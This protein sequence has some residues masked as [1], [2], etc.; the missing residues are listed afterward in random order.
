M[1]S[2]NYNKEFLG[3]LVKEGGISLEMWNEFARNQQNYRKTP[4]TKGINP[5][6]GKEHY[7]H[8]NSYS[9]LEN[10]TE[11]GLLAW[12]ESEC[13]GVAGESKRLEL[14]INKL[15]REFDAVFETLQ[16]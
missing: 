15:S 8:S 16:S 7:Y 11:I 2:I 10:D 9:V 14:E 12:E 13:I 1:K 4:P 6:T 5:F 3:F